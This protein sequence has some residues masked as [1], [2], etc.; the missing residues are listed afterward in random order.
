MKNILVPVGTKDGGLNN[1]RYAINFA[2]MSG[3]RVYVVNI[4]KE[5][6]KVAGLTKVNQLM[7]EDSEAILNNLLDQV[8]TKGVEVIARPIKGDPFEA[9]HRVSKAMNIDLIIMSPQSVE[10]KDEVYLGNV[11]GK[12]VKQTEIPVLV[13]PRDYLF[14]KAESI[15]LAFKKTT[16]EKENVLVPLK[17]I[18]GLFS[19]KIHLLA[20]NTPDFPDDGTPIASELM[21]IQSSYTKTKNATIFQGVLEHFQSHSPDMLCVLRRKRGFFQKLWEK[22]VVLKKEFHTTK[23]LLIL[24]GQE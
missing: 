8:D 4:Y 5:F 12:I 10:I 2:A 14:R 21:D 19:S 3:A 20:V 23:P 22:N 24:R 11:T 6:S 9:I 15:L 1:L 18:A 7:I 17:D 16:F 13:V